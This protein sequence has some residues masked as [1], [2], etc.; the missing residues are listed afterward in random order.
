MGPHTGS[1]SASAA[2]AACTK[3]IYYHTLN[4]VGVK[5]PCWC[6]PSGLTHSGF[7]Q[8]YIPYHGTHDREYV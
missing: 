5:T 3:N 2:A 1:F 7:P 8:S 6:I 4:V